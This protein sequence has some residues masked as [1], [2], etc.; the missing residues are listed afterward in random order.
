AHLSRRHIALKSTSM[1]RSTDLTFFDLTAALCPTVPDT[2]ERECMVITRALR[3]SSPGREP[4]FFSRQISEA[5][6]FYLR[7]N[8]P[9]PE[10]F[11]VVCG[12]SER[13]ASDYHV[14]RDNFPYVGV[15]FVAGGE[16][17]LNMNGQTFPLMSGAVFA[18]GP[19]V[20]HDLRCR[21]DNPM[22]KYF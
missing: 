6:R 1:V 9:W 10:G 7:L 3:D 22:T 17:T 4:A 8:A 14:A 21:P 11:N 5:Q 18:Y 12:G 20:A 2:G 13:C 15:E 19:G 16:G